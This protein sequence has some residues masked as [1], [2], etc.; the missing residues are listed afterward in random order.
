MK[1]V[2]RRIDY[3]QQSGC[4]AVMIETSSVCNASCVFCPNKKMER[5]QGVMSDEV[6]DVVVERLRRERIAPPLIDLFDVG[7]PLLDKSLF[8][9]VRILKAAF[10][11]AGVR[12]TTNFSLADERVVGEVLSSGLDSIHISLNASNRES[13]ERIM[14]L[15]WDRTLRNVDDLIERRNASKSPLKIVLRMVLCQDNPKEERAFV[16]KW[17]GKVDSLLLQRAVDWG[18][19]VEVASPYPTSMRL[20]PCNDLFERIVILSSGDMALCCQ[21]S[22]AS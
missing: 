5:K 4:Y 2:A 7:E 9:R 15:H 8:S 1:R 6:F 21:D 3:V 19:N 18:G 17:S 14:G 16:R 13:Y 10:P 22:R 12:T 11:A 20:Y